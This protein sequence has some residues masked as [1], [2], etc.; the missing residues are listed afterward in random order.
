MRRSSEPVVVTVSQ[1]P[2][3]EPALLPDVLR[4]LRRL[5]ASG[6]DLSRRVVLLLTRGRP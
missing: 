6:D 1:R 4:G 2:E 3:R 5:A